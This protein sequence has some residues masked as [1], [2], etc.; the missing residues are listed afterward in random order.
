MGI[1]MDIPVVLSDVSV[2]DDYEGNF[3]TRRA[4][5]WTLTFTLKGYLFGPVRRGSVIKFTETNI[6]NSLVANTQLQAVNVQPG[7]TAN[8]QP[9]T[10][11]NSSISVES[12]DAEDNFGYVVTI[13]E[14]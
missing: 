13:T 1:V 10:D 9:T 4:I 8:G 11:A 2:S 14:P 6:F 12:I 7:L 5:I 3:E